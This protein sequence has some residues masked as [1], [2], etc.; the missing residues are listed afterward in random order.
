MNCF[1]RFLLVSLLTLLYGCATH[2]LL[3]STTILYV[4][5]GTGSPMGTC[6]ANRVYLQ[7]DAAVGEW[8]WVCIGGTWSH[9]VPA[10]AFVTL[11]DGV[12]ISWDL[13]NAPNG[14]AKVTLGGN[15]TLNVSNLK[16]GATY[17]LY[18]MQDSMGSRG[19]ALGTGCTWKISGGGS[20][21]I[22][23][24]TGANAVD[25]LTFAYDGT[26]CYGILTKNFN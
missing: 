10:P 21:A 11:M 23:P 1:R 25:V 22:T 3:A 4:T 17:S 15:R 20:G 14:T 16:N 13:A 19:L 2:A 8:A 24:S 7:T 12:T 18:I 26:N 5:S 9:S 6:S